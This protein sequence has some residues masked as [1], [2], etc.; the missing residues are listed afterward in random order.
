MLDILICKTCPLI[1]VFYY[2]NQQNIRQY[3]KIVLWLSCFLKVIWSDEWIRER[4]RT[5]TDIQLFFVVCLFCHTALGILFSL[6]RMKPETSAVKARSPNHR[7]TREFPAQWF[8][9]GRLGCKDTSKTWMILPFFF[10]IACTVF[11][12][13]V[14]GWEKKFA[15]VSW[16]SG[17][18]NIS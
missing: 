11:F 12:I 18:K 13:C 15:S 10:R 4:K 17:K 3:P 9:L 7:T 8:L 16:A 5:S 1:W 14:F 2:L 6:P